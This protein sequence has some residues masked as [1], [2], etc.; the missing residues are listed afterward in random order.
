LIAEAGLAAV[1]F[2]ATDID[3]LLILAGFFAARRI[4][5]AAIVI[6]QFLGIGA[7]VAVSAAAAWL[8]IGV[9]QK[10]IA[11]LGLVPLGMGLLALRGLRR[12]SAEVDDAYGHER[13]LLLEKRIHA[14]AL[15][16]AAVTF[17]NGGDNLG[18]YIP[19]FAAQA[20]ALPVFIVVFAVGTGIW[21]WLAHAI[22]AHPRWGTGIRRHGAAALPFVLMALG[23]WILS[24]AFREAG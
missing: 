11:L 4:R 17:A 24:A 21:C 16:V 22:V 20:N 9:P 13:E 15:A 23:A 19:L 8:A 1:V 10:W 18:V 5:P 7:L 2:A 3:D 12:G 6:G 14:P